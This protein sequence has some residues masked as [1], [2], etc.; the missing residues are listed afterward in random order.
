MS[1]IDPRV[2]SKHPVTIPTM[3]QE[4]LGQLYAVLTA[5]CWATS[6]TLFER[7][8]HRIG[9]VI[10]NFLRLG[11]AVVMLGMICLI[12]RG[13]FF[14][15]DIPQDVFFWITL[16]GLL[17]FFL[18]DMCLFRAFVL[19]GARRALLMLSLAPCFAALLDIL[20]VKPPTPRMLLG[21]GI[22][23]T[24]VILVILQRSESHETPHSRRE[25]RI[26]ILL[27][28]GAAF[29]QAL[30]ASTADIALR[31]GYEALPATFVRALAGTVAFGLLIVLTRRI[32]DLYR[33]LQD[34]KALFLLTTGAVI[35]PVIG[36]TLFLASIARVQPSVTQTIL[37]TIPVLMLPIAHFS[38]RDRITP[39]SVF[40]T[41]VAVT[42]VI[43]LC[44]E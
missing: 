25:L 29:F 33:G 41:L 34:L 1:L 4:Q 21:M 9:S 30:G 37:T 36:V 13:R 2:K 43:V 7:A 16:S 23:L 8:G 38:G 28:A 15:T 11:V 39:M 20:I 27:G 5:F 10:V 24:G 3:A 35:G 12:S 18:C 17:G 32:S 22:T 19:A 26:G 31:G 6:A 14:P 42:G 44:W 40:G